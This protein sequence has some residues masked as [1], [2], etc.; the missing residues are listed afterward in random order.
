MRASV[1]LVFVVA[2]YSASPP[3][4]VPCTPALENCPRGQTCQLVGGEHICTGGAGDG[5][6]A[7]LPDGGDPD[8]TVAG[9]WTLVNTRSRAMANDVTFPATTAGN[10]IVVGIETNAAG[11]VTEVTDNRNSTYVPVMGSRAV[12]VQEN[13]AIEFWY[14]REVNA[15]ATRINARAPTVY[16]VAMWKVAGLDKTAPLGNVAKVDDQP[17]MTTVMGAPITTTTTGEFVVSVAIVQLSVAGIAMGNAFI[18]D[19][20]AYGN[21]WA[22]LADNAAPPAVYQAAWANNT[23]G[24]SCTSSV[25]FRR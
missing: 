9:T 25:A 15:D 11:A 22:H 3:S 14:A 17:A 6:D 20:T 19:H 7:G 18:N 16:A 8:A 12:N 21:G 1:C 24:V 13:F 2:C 10:L 5:D 23:N 4:G